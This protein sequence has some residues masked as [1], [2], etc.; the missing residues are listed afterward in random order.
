MQRLKHPTTLSAAFVVLIF[1]IFSGF[2]V[3]AIGEDISTATPAPPAPPEA[4]EPANTQFSPAPIVNAEGGPRVVTGD[5]TYTNPFFTSGVS[6]PLIIL[7]DQAGFVDRNEYFLFPPESQVLGQITS[8]FFTSPF[9]YSLAL[10]I[11]PQG[12]LR[13]VDNDGEAD[14]GVMVFAVAYWSNTFGDPFL[15]ERDLYGGGWSGAYASTRVSSDPRERGEYVGGQIIIYAPDNQQGFPAGFG[16]DGE[17]FTQDDPIVAVPQGYTVVDLDQEPF[18]FDRSQAYAMDLYEPEGSALVD[19]SDLSYMAAFDAMIEK[20]RTE[21]AFTE[22]YNIDWDALS[23]RYRP[24]VV[25]AQAAGDAVGFARAIRDVLWQVPD[26]HVGMSLQLLFPEIRQETD[27]GLGLAMRELDS[28]RVITTLVLEG[29]PAAEAGIAVGADVLAINGTPIQQ[30]LEEAFVWEHASFSTAHNRRLQQLRYAIRFP[31]GE[32]VTLT[33]RNPGAGQQTASMTTIPERESFTASSLDADVSGLELPV[34]FE[35]LDNGIGYVSIY[36][37]LDDEFLT[38]QLWERMINEF[39]N[40]GVLGIIVDMRNNGGGSPW[41]ATQM[42]AYFYDEPLVVG[43][44]SRYRE[45]LGEFYSDERGE[46]RFYLP[47]ADQRYDGP[48]AVL[49]SPSC[50]SACETFTHSMTLQERAEIVGYY[51]TGGLGGGIN[52]FRM[53]ENIT[54]TFTVTRGL[55][56]DGNIHIEGKGI[57]PTLDVPVSEETLFSAGDP[58]LE[59]AADAIIREARGILRDGGEIILSPDTSGATREET[60]QA[61]EAIQYEVFLPADT[62]VSFYAQGNDNPNLDLEMR[63]YDATGRTVQFENDNRDLGIPAPAIEGLVTSSNVDIV[64]EVKLKEDQEAGNFTLR[65]QTSPR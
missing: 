7:E 4:S 39:K 33:Y 5:V 53:P 55:D 28:G 18:V 24:D 16:P 34:E 19:Y 31:I 58:V 25:R 1:T 22:Y 9:S 20:F 57:A 51:P 6:Q 42:A 10:P 65:I 35:I 3:L 44:A 64:L 45:E 11:E 13:D 26:G 32:A 47:S 46:R 8:D 41:L 37:F 61:G 17:L 15:E 27:G 38:V 12:T 21:Y 29:M 43:N 52:Q 50:L 63:I 30:A 56:A 54:I 14:T 60:I 23:E 40:Q 59:A 48:V 36:S 62:V 49:V 2:G